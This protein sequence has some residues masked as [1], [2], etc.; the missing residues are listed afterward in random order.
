MV[1]GQSTKVNIRGLW[2][3]LR[4]PQLALEPARDLFI[5]QGIG[6]VA[7]KTLERARPLAA[8]RQR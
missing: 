6:A 4:W 8:R 2:P 5:F 7:L 3:L 1:P